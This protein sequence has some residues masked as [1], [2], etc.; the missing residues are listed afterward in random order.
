[1]RTP[2]TAGGLA[3]K[4]EELAL[5]YHKNPAPLGEGEY[6]CPGLTCPGVQRLLRFANHVALEALGAASPVRLEELDAD[7]PWPLTEILTQLADAVDHLLRDHDCDHMGWEVVCIARDR[8]RAMVVTLRSALPVPATGPS[9][10]ALLAEWRAKADAEDA[11]AKRFE[12]HTGDIAAIYLRSCAD[13]LE[14]ALAAGSAPSVIQKEVD[15]ED[16]DR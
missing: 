8:A 6:G 10:R 16:Q 4:L 15:R 7:T 13:E 5:A 9:L 1:M 3:A 11:E 2:E 14:A 12:G